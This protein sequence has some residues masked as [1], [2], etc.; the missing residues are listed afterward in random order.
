[1]YIRSV[2]LLISIQGI[3]PPILIFVQTKARAQQLYRELVYDGIN[4]D[5]IHSDRLEEVVCV[6]WCQNKYAILAIAVVWDV[7]HIV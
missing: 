2:L 4:A 5:T 6:V 7:S 3:K 1:M